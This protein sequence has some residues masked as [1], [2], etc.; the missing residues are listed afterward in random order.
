MAIGFFGELITE[1]LGEMAGLFTAKK[2][3]FFGNLAGKVITNQKV[4][5]FVGKKAEELFGQVDESGKTLEEELLTIDLINFLA[6]VGPEVD[7]FI[8]ELRKQERG[9]EKV[10]A[11]RVFLASGIK[12]GS[13]Q[14]KDFV[15]NPDGK[16]KPSEESYTLLDV[17][18][19]ESFIKRLLAKKTFEERVLFLED[20]GVFSTMKKV[21]Q[22]H[23]AVKKATDFLKKTA[24]DAF[25]ATKTQS[26]EIKL[27]LRENAESQ[28]I[29][30]EE[31]LKKAKAFYE[32][33]KKKRS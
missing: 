2:L 11:F 31:A 16:G 1:V 24:G 27:S 33:S 15:L 4:K 5:D 25:E 9:E 23:P 10:I 22:P 8:A 21:A 30:S 18:W 7:S 19:G 20:Q 29:S 13:R 28:K 14:R 12:K 26:G 32:A 17:K 3:G 6:Q